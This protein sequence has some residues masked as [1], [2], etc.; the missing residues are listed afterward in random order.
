MRGRLLS[1]GIELSQGSSGGAEMNNRDRLLAGLPV[2]DSRLQL[3]GIST[4]VLEGGAGPPVVLLHGPGEFSA[5]WGRV[6]PELVTTNRV[7]VPDLPGH[8]ASGLPAGRL[9]VE[10]VLT[11]LSDLIERTCHRPPTVVGHLLGGAIALRFAADRPDRVRSL[12]LVDSYGLSWNLPTL[13]FAAPLLAFVVRPTER[14][15]DRFLDKCFVDFDGVREQFGDRWDAFGA[16][17]LEWAQTKT[18]K[19]TMRDLMPRFGLR[20]IPATHLEQITAP[21]SLIWGRDDLQTPLRVAEAASS[22]YGWPLH[23]IDG[24]RDDPFVE[25]PAAALRALRAELAAVAEH[26]AER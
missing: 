8:G 3:A 5:L 13:R 20:P 10:R 12:V 7:V 25:Q 18:S 17:A 11:W 4:A 26:E 16:Q 24:A 15:R 23:V 14:T 1:V 9:D 21:T 6:I 22:R 2:N 19:A